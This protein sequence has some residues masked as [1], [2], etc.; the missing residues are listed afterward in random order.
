MQYKQI[1]ACFLT[2]L[3]LVNASFA[4][5]NERMHVGNEIA[6]AFKH[7]TPSV[8]LRLRHEEAKQGTLDK[9]KATT[10]RSAVGFETAEFS[11]SKI[12]LEIIDVANFFGQR[13]N[14]AVTD[15]SKPWYSKINDAKGAGITEGNLAFYGL[16]KNLITVGRQFIRLDNRRMVAKNDWR[17]FPQS[18]DALTVNNTFI[19]SLDLFYGLLTHINTTQANSRSA[20]GR[21]TLHTH[22]INGRWSGYQYGTITGYVYLNR[23][24]TIPTN[25]HGMLGFIV[26]GTEEQTNFC[27][28]R[29]ELARQRSNF[30]NP[31]KYTA[32][33][34]YGRI[35]KTVDMFT[36][37]LGAER[38]SGNASHANRNFNMPLGTRH[39]FNGYAEVFSTTPSQGLQDY[40][41]A[42]GVKHKDLAV[43]LTYHYFLFDKTLS[44][45]RAGNEVD[46]LIEFKINE[47]F[48]ISTAYAS[49]NPSNKATV[50]T[51]RFWVMLDAM[52]L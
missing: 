30:G 24:R 11:K 15:L 21:R 52:V 5:E 32:H 40:F 26:T 42:V 22:L 36:G 50:R 49:Y 45:K 1:A 38:I 41:A 28:F 7:G 39:E 23:D 12:K 13:Y 43:T 10:L 46:L 44:T 17:Q 48:N 27:D 14:P 8:Q 31:V 16:N 20:G 4:D 18:F 37:G 2:S 47:Q 6:E 29:V 25:S 33:Y 34:A 19:E 51:R 9:A 35:D 3:C